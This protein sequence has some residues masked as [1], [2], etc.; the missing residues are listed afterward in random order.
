VLLLI[1]RANFPNN[2]SPREWLAR[3]E[4]NAPHQS[5]ENVFCQSSLEVGVRAANDAR[6]RHRENSHAAKKELQRIILA[7]MAP[8]AHK[9][10]EIRRNSFNGV[11]GNNRDASVYGD[12]AKSKNLG[13]LARVSG[14]RN[15]LRTANEFGA[16]DWLYC[17]SHRCRW[18]RHSAWTEQNG[19]RI[20][21][22]SFS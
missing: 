11:C 18:R 4:T 20:G 21:A 16:D 2:T 7:K 8:A 22:P 3:R 1:E 13:R 17:R 14:Q 19:E 6:F 12:D 15:S 9:T 5:H 10:R